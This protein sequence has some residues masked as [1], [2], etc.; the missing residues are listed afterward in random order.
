M[1]FEQGA[2]LNRFVDASIPLTWAVRWQAWKPSLPLLICGSLFLVEQVAFRLWLNNRSLR[3][4][5]PLLAA[6]ALVPIALI[7]IAFEVQ[8]RITHRSKRKLKL[9]AKHISISP[10]KYNR[11]ALERIRSWRL[12]PVAEAPVF[13]KLMLE[14]ALD[15]KHKLL[16]EWSMVFRPEQ[17][18]AFLS[19]MEQLRQTSQT[20]AEVLL[21]TQPLVRRKVKRRLRS[22]AAVALGFYCIMHGLPLLGGSLFPSSGESEQSG[23][24]SQFTAREKAKLREFLAL[25]FASADEFRKFMIVASGTLTILGAGFY[26]WGLS[27]IKKE[28]ALVAVPER[29][30][31]ARNESEDSHVCG[32]VEVSR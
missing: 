26:F 32:S 4:E 25:H 15:K 28:N 24:G 10:A 16:R 30:D 23:R 11:V 6:C 18:G 31:T 14:Y 29:D 8:V 1:Q 27:A 3:S 22:G 2:E 9:G 5:L 13:S 21:L 20:S 19:E 17:K 12:E 7:M